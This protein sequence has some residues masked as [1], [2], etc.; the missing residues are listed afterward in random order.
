MRTFPDWFKVR[1]YLR[2]TFG[3]EVARQIQEVMNEQ[4]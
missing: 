1:N 4:L 2:V 3:S